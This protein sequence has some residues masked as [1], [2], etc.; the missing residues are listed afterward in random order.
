MNTD[1]FPVLSP[2]DRNP[3]RVLVPSFTKQLSFSKGPNSGP[4]I[5]EKGNHVD[6][7]NK[8]NY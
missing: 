5:E 3:V 4:E 8:C 6:S 7:I 2:K 1:G